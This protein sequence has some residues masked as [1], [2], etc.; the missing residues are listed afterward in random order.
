MHAGVRG[1]GV[2]DS[3]QDFPQ[4]ERKVL[5]RNKRLRLPFL[6]LGVADRLVLDFGPV[7]VGASPGNGTDLMK[8]NSNSRAPTKAAPTTDSEITRKYL[9][10]SRSVL[11]PSTYR[12]KGRRDSPPPSL[13]L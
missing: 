13:A 8:G 11:L 12:S 7:E 6:L 5:A 3:P 4:Q 1:G 2:G 9:G 10:E